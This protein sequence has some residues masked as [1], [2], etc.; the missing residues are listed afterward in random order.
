M[1]AS[2]S[3]CIST[4]A[5]TPN[6]EFKKMA[7]VPL[8]SPQASALC[9][10]VEFPVSYYNGLAQVSLPIYEIVTGD[11]SVPISLSYHGGGIKVQE[12]ASWVGLG[13]ALSAGGVI[14]HDIK[15]VDDDYGY[16]HQFNKVFPD[17]LG[18]AYRG[19]NSMAIGKTCYYSVYSKLGVPYDC[20]NLYGLLSGGNVDGEPDMYVY[21]FGN[22]SGKFF[23]GDGNFV[24]LS[25]NNIQFTQ[26]IGTGFTALAPDGYTY[27][28]NAIEKAWAYPTPYATN[29]AY[30]LTKITSPKGK[31]VTFQYKSFKTLIDEHDQ[32][33]HQWSGQFP[34]I[35]Y[36]WGNDG[37]V[38]QL[39]AFSEYFANC[40]FI[41][42]YSSIPPTETAGLHQ[43]YSSTTSSNL[44][45]DKIVFDNGYIDF[46][47][48]PRNDLYGVKLD[49][50]N[51]HRGPLVK[52]I[53][54]TYNY[55]VSNTN[56]DD[57]YDPNKVGQFLGPY[58]SHV[59]YYPQTY[60]NQRLKL[61]NVTIE[62]T[63]SH[64]FEYFDG[65]QYSTLPYKTSFSQDLWGYYNG[66][67]GNRSLIPDYGLYSLQVSI[68]SELS[69]WN[70]GNRNPDDSY[71]KA[72]LL[73]KVVYP[74]GGFSNF[75][76]D[77]NQFTN[78]SPQQQ[79][80]YKEARYGGV[81][82]GAGTKKFYFTITT[83]TKC[84]ING[85]LYC[86]GQQDMNSPSYNCGCTFCSG[87]SPEALYAMIEKV[88]PSTY[89]LVQ[90]YVDWEFDISKTNI[91]NA[92]G[93]IN[94]ANQTFSPGTYCITVNYPDSHTPP[95]D[96]ANNRRAELYV[97]FYELV[98][99]QTNTAANGA[100]V[101]VKSIKN[102]DPVT[103][104]MMEKQF[105]YSGGKLM[106]YPLY[107]ASTT[108]Q[109]TQAA[110]GASTNAANYINYYLYSSPSMPYSFSA[111]G[112]PTG[113]DL[114][115]E[116]II[117]PSSVGK[118]QFEFKNIPDI[119][120]V[121]PGTY[122]PGVPSAGYMDNGFLK[123]V[124][125][126]DK[127]NVLLRETLNDPSI[128]NTS[129]Y[130]PFKGRFATD[131]TTSAKFSEYFQMSFY[132]VNV[133]K[134]LTTKT[135]VKEFLPGNTMISEKNFT[136]NAKGL[137]SQESS[138]SSNG[139]T[140]TTTYTYP[141]DYTGVNNG[142]IKDLKDRNMIA[143]PLEV[144]NKKDGL[145]TGGAFT[146]YLSHDNIITADKIYRIETSSPSSIA[147]TAPGGVIPAA[148][149]ISGTL[150]YDANGNIIQSRGEN[151]V[152][153]SYL[154]GYN[155]AYPVA[156]VIGA[157][158]A[159]IN[160]LITSGV[161]SLSIL[162]NP[163]STDEQVRQ[164]TDNLRTGLAGSKALITTYT[165]TTLIG[166]TSQTDEKGLTT[167]YNYDTYNRLTTIKDQQGK[168]LNYYNYYYSPTLKDVANNSFYNETITKI[169][170]KQCSLDEFGRIQT[171][172]DV[173]YTVTAEK[174]VG[175]TQQ[176]AN[177]L[178]MAE[179]DANGQANA[180]T[181]GDC[182]IYA[183]P[184]V[185][186]EILNGSGNNVDIKY[187]CPFNAGYLYL[188]IQDVATGVILN[189]YQPYS[190]SPSQTNFTIT[191]TKGK[192]YK[193]WLQAG[194][195]GMYPSVLYSQ[196]ITINFP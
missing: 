16:S 86:N 168:I 123:R 63:S 77:L 104:Q 29:T 48:S 155:K 188:F 40:K 68:P 154:W 58:D 99:G 158:Y 179:I 20:N 127:N 44:Y 193:F 145:V 105:T 167:F 54:F 90:H 42:G 116:T 107:Y 53:P 194:G 148:L 96:V 140:L 137:L 15:G 186:K 87:G 119:T 114:V 35:N 21:N 83:E 30:H 57:M 31:V 117:G 112:S 91:K 192:E 170:S 118:T 41:E 72:G 11:I 25:N 37:T 106:R 70:G 27:T 108:M 61:L 46:V 166:M 142:W 33:G 180:N 88:S 131:E 43:S 125:V 172:T 59:D 3:I 178:A 135:T 150:T 23:S 153:T 122:L 69:S 182:Y 74:T 22:Y 52:S 10:Y 18:N 84:D 2:L 79:N 34:N 101:R 98:P 181:Y 139:S 95:G 28:F 85:V 75:S 62:P 109:Y 132:P 160:S 165:Y 71:I 94:M 185:L 175:F 24:D 26:Q 47:K 133:G 156:R 103:L 189:N 162:S 56:D 13:W 120:T 60:R 100:G 164:Q 129:T 124:G 143:I 76:Y 38:M 110:G 92:G 64:S 176:A 45:L 17:N 134:I 174:Y 151:D 157:E 141:L 67:K 138:P 173:P 50:I 36:A 136:Y 73:K 78:L 121:A 115:T 190:L 184:P 12:E 93:Y 7:S 80:V 1:L 195:G 9:K 39:P 187:L 161:I 55:F 32:A 130:W 149:K 196:Y 102:F 126:Y 81:D 159:A 49:A 152:Y 66:P 6:N 111:Q 191:L 144:Y 51:I 183:G 146:T 113:Y 147:S 82:I 8:Q 65:G 128:G 14:S 89:A 97:S 169:F 177:A 171:G 19:T 4:S 163:Y 5:Q